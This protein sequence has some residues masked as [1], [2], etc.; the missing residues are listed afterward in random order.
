MDPVHYDFSPVVPAQQ[1]GIPAE[2]LSRAMVAELDRS[3]HAIAKD[4]ASDSAAQRLVWLIPERHSART[5]FSRTNNKRQFR[6][7]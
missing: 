6:F 3:R 1:K 7:E 4:N 5:H 2:H